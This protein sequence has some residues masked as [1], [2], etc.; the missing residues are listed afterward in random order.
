MGHALCNVLQDP[1]LTCQ[2]ASDRCP[3]YDCS[4]PALS[5]AVRQRLGA[6]FHIVDWAEAVIQVRLKDTP[7]DVD[8]KY[9]SECAQGHCSDCRQSPA[10][11]Y[12]EASQCRYHGSR[13]KTETTDRMLA[14]VEGSREGAGA[15]VYRDQKEQLL[16]FVRPVRGSKGL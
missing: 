11:R 16:W 9:Y 7:C 13:V 6:I 15:R 1:T 12:R 3:D 10:V 14:Y 5:S 4:T 2:Y 8:A